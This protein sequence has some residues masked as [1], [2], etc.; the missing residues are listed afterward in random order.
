MNIFN[1]KNK[2]LSFLDKVY[3]FAK[4]KG[5][6]STL[7]VQ[8]EF[9]IG[10]GLAWRSIDALVTLG[11]LNKCGVPGHYTYQCNEKGTAKNKDESI[12]INLKNQERSKLKKQLWDKAY[13]KMI[14]IY[15]DLPDKAI[16]ERFYSEKK[17]FNVS[18]AIILIDLIARIRSSSNEIGFQ[19]SLG[20]TEG[21][22]FVSYLLGAVENNPLP[23]HY[24]CPNCKHIELVQDKQYPLDM[25]SKPCDCGCNMTADG[26]NIPYETHI[27]MSQISRPNVWVAP[28]FLERAKRIVEE[29][30][31]TFKIVTL[32]KGKYH[33]YV[34]V[35]YDGTENEVKSPDNVDNLYDCYSHITIVP[36]ELHE[37]LFE[38]EKNTGIQMSSIAL[39]DPSIMRGFMT[40]DIEDIPNFH[41]IDSHRLYMTD[42]FALVKP[43]SRLDLLQILGAVHGTNTWRKNADILV[44]SGVPISS[45][46]LHRD[47]L[48]QLLQSKFSSHGCE[49]NGLAFNI[50][51]LTRRGI[52]NTKGMDASTRALLE[53]L[54]LEDWVIPYMEKIVYMFPKAHCVQYLNF[55][56]AFMWYKI[57]YPDVYSKVMEGFFDNG[58]Q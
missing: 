51:Q 52:Y 12:I 9:K 53:S 13:D 5:E 18:D 32:I 21:S 19:I 41:S 54:E 50:S 24:Y 47:D 44:Q 22:C 2:T 40:Q 36:L 35:P 33:K 20:G 29:T 4:K 30:M 26:Y 10:Y 57:N 49:G 6:I 25:P 8:R 42:L 1:K 46:P 27:G 39:D 56:M 48:F 37:R 3:Q 11:L 28:A 31:P 55:S 34:F 16:L 45:I 58:K 15:G 43:Q 38:L 7:T 14:A 17:M 23:L